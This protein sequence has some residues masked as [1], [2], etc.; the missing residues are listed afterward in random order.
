MTLLP[1]M[2]SFPIHAVDKPRI[3]TFRLIN[4]QLV[5]EFSPNLMIHSENVVSMCKVSIKLLGASLHAFHKVEGDNVKWIPHL[6]AY[7][8]DNTSFGLAGAA[9]L[10]D[11]R[12]KD[13]F[14]WLTKPTQKL[15]HLLSM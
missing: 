12:D 15:P 9:G 11:T 8:N 4:D 5:G 2:Y 1:G 6:K 14:V 13:P 10:L 7:V 3:T